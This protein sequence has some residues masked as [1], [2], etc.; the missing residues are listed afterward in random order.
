MLKKKMKPYETCRVYLT[1]LL[2]TNLN[3]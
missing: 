1:K 3:F 2:L